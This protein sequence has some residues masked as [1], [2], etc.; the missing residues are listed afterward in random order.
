[1]AWGFTLSAVKAAVYM[2][3][4]TEDGAVLFVTAQM[5]AKMMPDCWFSARAGEHF[6]AEA[7]DRFIQTIV[8]GGKVDSGDW[9]CTDPG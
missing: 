8:L 4:S 9:R 5:T 6:S 2:E 3:H 7:L 1:M